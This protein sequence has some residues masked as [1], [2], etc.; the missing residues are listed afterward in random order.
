MH[1]RVWFVCFNYR[2]LLEASW[3]ETEPFPHHLAKTNSM[4]YRNGKR[5]S[6]IWGHFK[7]TDNAK[8]NRNVFFFFFFPF[9]GERGR[10]TFPIAPTD[11]F[12]LALYSRIWRKN[13]HTKQVEN[14]TIS[15][16]QPCKIHHHIFYPSKCTLLR[17]SYIWLYLD[18]K[19]S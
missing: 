6:W 13:M 5:N 10:G 7:H 2:S 3:I 12:D 15:S 4:P 8:W 19:I 11:H 18:F 14:G 9:R 16:G 1:I 17:S